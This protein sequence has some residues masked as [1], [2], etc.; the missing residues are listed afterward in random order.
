MVLK[1]RGTFYPTVLALNF[2]MENRTVAA[3]AA[4]GKTIKSIMKV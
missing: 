2:Q 4:P 1:G 3:Y